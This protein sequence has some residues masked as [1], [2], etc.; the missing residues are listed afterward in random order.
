MFLETFLRGKEVFWPAL[1]AFKNPKTISSL[2]VFIFLKKTLLSS[3]NMTL[4]QEEI[5][6]Y[7]KSQNKW[8]TMGDSNTKFFHIST[9]NKRRKLKIQV[10]KDGNGN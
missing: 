3:F 5:L 4:F 8:L 1:R 6:W 10:L 2:I 9:L 7:Q